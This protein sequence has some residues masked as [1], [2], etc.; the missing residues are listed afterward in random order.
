MVVTRSNRKRSLKQTS[1]S[2]DIKSKKRRASRV[3][4]SLEKPKQNALPKTKATKA[5]KSV[6][7]IQDIP[8]DEPPLRLNLIKPKKI[9]SQLKRNRTQEQLMSA[10]QILTPKRRER[11]CKKKEKSILPNIQKSTPVKPKV[12]II[13]PS[14]EIV[15]DPL[16]VQKHNMIWN[17]LLF[18]FFF[19]LFILFNRIRNFDT[20]IN[21]MNESVFECSDRVVYEE[22]DMEPVEHLMK[23]IETEVAKTKTLQKEL[24]D[25]L[26]LQSLER[27]NTQKELQDLD[28]ILDD[29]IESIE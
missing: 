6:I 21:D 17:F 9:A 2:E 7:N 20:E 5:P 16:S 22:C 13:K 26:K 1:I 19:V 4:S 23:Q 29:I 27:Q 10:L 24:E 15:S 8:V 25:F 28:A 14:R 11:S 3:A 18:G 12:R